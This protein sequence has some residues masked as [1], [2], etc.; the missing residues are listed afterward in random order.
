MTNTAIRTAFDKH[1]W[2]VDS[3]AASAVHRSG[4]TVRAERKGTRPPAIDI[5]GLSALASTPWALKA[6]ALVEEGIALLEAR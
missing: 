4:L 6:H 3:A 2:T 5:K 1:D